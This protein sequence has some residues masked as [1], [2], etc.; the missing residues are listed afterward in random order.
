MNLNN[1]ALDGEEYLHLAID[2]MRR[3]DHGAA[4]AYLKD[5]TAKF[6][7]DARLAYMLGAENAQIGLYDRAQAEM[8]RAIELD[9]SLHTARFQLGLLQLTQGDTEGAMQTWLGLDALAE[10]HSLRLFRDGLAALAAD[11]FA[12]AREKIQSGIKGNNFS[13]DLNQDMEK[14]LARIPS[15]QEGTAN[16]EAEGIGHV[17][18]NAYQNTESPA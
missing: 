7:Q 12:E 18:F 11:R 16:G 15:K 1:A 14:L 2:A 10:G 5:G 6:P 3:E 8:R 13:P 17:W 9:P 4:L